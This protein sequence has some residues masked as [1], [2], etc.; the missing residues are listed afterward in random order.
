[1]KEPIA[2]LT[3]LNGNL[4]SRRP[5]NALLPASAGPVPRTKVP[6]GSI[7]IPWWRHPNPLVSE[8]IRRASLVDLTRDPCLFD[9]RLPSYS[10]RVSR[11]IRRASPDPFDARHLSIR[12]ASSALG[13][14]GISL[15]G[16]RKATEGTGQDAHVDERATTNLLCPW[17]SKALPLGL[18]AG[19]FVPKAALPAC[20]PSYNKVYCF[21]FCRKVVEWPPDGGTDIVRELIGSV[22]L[23]AH[24]G[25]DSCEA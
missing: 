1:M 9:A 18:G 14:R 5:P 7:Q 24:V 13:D 4:R 25:R 19:D 11:P 6:G 23:D 20:V 12:R 8:G 17:V 15:S 16:R 21:A 22:K 2:V 10:T 3:R